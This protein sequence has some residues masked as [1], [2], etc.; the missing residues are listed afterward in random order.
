MRRTLL[1]AATLAAATGLA[2]TA[3]GHDDDG[4][5]PLRPD[6][7]WTTVFTPPAG[8]GIEGLTADKRGVLYAPG[9]VTG[10][11]CPVFKAGT[12]VVGT[13]PAPCNPAGLAFGPDGRLYIADNGKIMV[14]RPNDRTPPTAE[15]YAEGVPGSNGVAWDERGDLWVS[16]GGT[17]Q[18]RVWRI[19]RD[20]VPVEALR[21]QPMASDALPGG[22]GRDVRGLPP[23]TITI[24][25]T[26]RAASNT[27]GSQAIVANGLAFGRDGTLFIADT[28]RGAIWRVFID[29][30]GRIL[31]KTGC[32]TTFAANT[33][34][35]DN[36]LVQHPYLD[37]A[38]G[39]VLDG[40]GTIFVAANERNAMIAVTEKGRAVE[41]Y[42]NA[43]GADRL[44]N[45]GPLEFPTSPVLVGKRLCTTSSDTARRDNFP[46]TPGQ[47]PKINCVS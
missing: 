1:A 14:L 40:E 11:P 45:V 8:V 13:L 9:R 33:L 18:G 27:L 31:S 19:G 3:I 10:A 25:E 21:V 2:T 26:S 39:I 29:R 37:G 28:A 7:T 32:D 6:A 38:D 42:R 12:G 15:V 47:G 30:R 17:G 23:G 46:A 44:R 41:L 36:V 34:C 35:L 24:T 20:R 22:V 43:A 16:D 4:P 5:R